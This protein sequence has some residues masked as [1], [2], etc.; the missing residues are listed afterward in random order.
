MTSYSLP[1]DFLQHLILDQVIAT[2][3][4]TDAEREQFR[5]QV[6]SQMNYQSWLQQ[7]GVTADE[8][9]TWITR[10]FAIRRF[11]QQR[12]GKRLGSY[13]LE[14]KRQLDQVICSL[15]YLR[16]RDAARELYFRLVEGEQSFAE[17][18]RLYSQGAEAQTGGQLGPI[19]LGEL[20]PAL[21]R[22]FYGGR[23]GQLWE[24]MPVGEWTVIARLDQWLPVQ[25]DETLRQTLLNELLDQ[26]LQHQI[27]QQ[28]PS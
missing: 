3:R 22:R 2:V 19:A 13:F 5:Q 8:F 17:V 24:P 7:Q 4:Y 9:E 26:W 6:L 28:F 18:A 25:L 21:Q 11:Q 12:W 14:R 16:D 23:P 10:E 20:H 27:K 1:S 15:I